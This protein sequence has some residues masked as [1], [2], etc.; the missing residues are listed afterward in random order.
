MESMI[1]LTN[2]EMFRTGI[3]LENGSLSAVTGAFAPNDHF[4]MVQSGIIGN[5]PF[6]PGLQFNANLQKTKSCQYDELCTLLDNSELLS[7][8]LQVNGF[9]NPGLYQFTTSLQNL[10][11]EDIIMFTDGDL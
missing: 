7:A 6:Q 9:Y 4:A 10:A 8:N 1:K 5:T 2:E 3:L 11:I